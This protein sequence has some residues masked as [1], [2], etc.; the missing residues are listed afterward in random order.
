MTRLRLCQLLDNW[1]L[2]LV[3]CEYFPNTCLEQ[4]SDPVC[5]V[6]ISLDHRPESRLCWDFANLRR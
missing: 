1:N 6:Q 2:I 4:L 3:S 5:L